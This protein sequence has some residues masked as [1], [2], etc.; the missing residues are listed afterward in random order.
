MVLQC[1]HTCTTNSAT[2]VAKTKKTSEKWG[3]ASYLPVHMLNLGKLAASA[4]QAYLVHGNWD[5]AICRLRRCWH[6]VHADI[7]NKFLFQDV[8]ACSIVGGTSLLCPR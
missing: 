4:V 1:I 8:F 2:H 5:I 6:N 7:Q 3:F